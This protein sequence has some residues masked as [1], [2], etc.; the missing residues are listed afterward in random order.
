MTAACRRGA[1]AAQA[2]PPQD[3]VSRI[4][5]QILERVAAGDVAAWDVGIFDHGARAG[6][7]SRAHNQYP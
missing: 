2:R 5:A 3:R 7:W 1:G 6:L 4:C